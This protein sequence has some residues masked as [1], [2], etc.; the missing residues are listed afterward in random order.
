MHTKLSLNA[1]GCQ[2]AKKSNKKLKALL[3]FENA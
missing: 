1:K 3:T 2:N